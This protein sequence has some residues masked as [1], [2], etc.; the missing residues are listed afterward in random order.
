MPEGGKF[1]HNHK[2]ASLD[3]WTQ[4]EAIEITTGK[5]RWLS[6]CGVG[7]GSIPI[8][9]SLDGKPVI[10]VGRGGGHSPPEKPNGISLVDGSDGSTKW[11]LPL[12]NFMS[13]MTMNANGDQALVFH[14]GEHLWVDMRKGTI[15]KRVSF[16][17]DVPTCIRKGDG[18]SMESVTLPGSKP[19]SI[20]QQSNILVGDYHYFR[21]YTRPYLGRVHIKSGEVEMLQLPLQFVP[22]K[23]AAEDA[24]LWSKDEIEDKKNP[25]KKGKNLSY[26]ADFLNEVKNSRGFVV[27]GDKRSQGIG[28]GHYASA[29]PIAVGEHLYV[30][31]MS[32]NV[33][34]IRWNADQLNEDAIVAINDLGPAGKS[35]TRAS[36]SYSD[37]KLYAH[38]IRELICIGK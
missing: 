8:A 37:G 31:I 23:S 9:H 35:W 6:Q 3:M 16:T 29:I 1:G 33:F 12:D 5:R 10:L 34:V 30:P 25:L 24:L 13:T 22:G 20:T 19:R 26:H 38:T 2:N 11:T 36:L 14:K 28:W 15:E 4:L 18:F 32:G 7:M 17:T 27:M 21:S